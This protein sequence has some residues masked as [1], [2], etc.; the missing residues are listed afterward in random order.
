MSR[1]VDLI[2]FGFVGFMGLYRRSDIPICSSKPCG[3]R[4]RM[5]VTKENDETAVGSGL[6]LPKKNYV[7]ASGNATWGI[8]CRSNGSGA[9]PNCRCR[10]L[11]VEV[12]PAVQT[13]KLMQRKGQMANR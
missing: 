11:A 12:D 13:S 5:V 9:S 7:R 1:R 6:M 10:L 4:W 8:K 2:V 3:I